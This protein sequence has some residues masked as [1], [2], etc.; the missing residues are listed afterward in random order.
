MDNAELGRTL[1]QVCLRLEDRRK[2]LIEIWRHL[3]E[4]FAANGLRRQP[5]RG[6]GLVNLCQGFIDL[7]VGSR[8]RSLRP[9]ILLTAFRRGPEQLLCPTEVDLCQCQHRLALIE[10]GD[11]SAQKGDLVVEVLHGALQFPAPASGFGFNTARLGFRRQQVRLG[12]RHPGP[13]IV[14]LDLDQQLALLD[15]LKIVH[16]HPA[17]ITFDLGAERRDVAANVSIVGNLPDRQANPAVPLSSEQDDD[18]SGSDQN[19]EPDKSD[20][21]PRPSSRPR[22]IRRRSLRRRGQHRRSFVIGG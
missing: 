6:A 17:H 7:R 8:Q 4:I 2:G 9:I 14:I 20:P 13:I 12:L 15:P 22:H 10:S 5:Q 11:A 18:N 16:G 3:T 1:D 21:R 19:G